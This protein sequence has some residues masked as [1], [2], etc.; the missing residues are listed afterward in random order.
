MGLRASLHHERVYVDAN[1]F[2]YLI[3]GLPELKSQIAEFRDLL[4]DGAVELVTSELTLCET[5]VAPFRTGRNDLV[6]LYRDLIENSGAFDV[7]P[8]TRDTYMRASL[9]RADMAL[10]TPDAIHVATAVEAGCTVFLTHDRRL[11]TPRSIR[12]VIFG[13]S[14]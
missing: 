2:I 13:D 5:L 14:N 3:E 12:I 11:K 8:T 7:R 4:F 6:A 1:I 9:Y 10:K